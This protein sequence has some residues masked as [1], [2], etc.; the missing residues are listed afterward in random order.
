MANKK[1]KATTPQDVYEFILSKLEL[2]SEH[3][4]NLEQRGFSAEEIKALGYKSFTTKRKELV[5]ALEKQFGSDEL[6]NAA[7]PGLYKNETGAL[8]ISGKSGIA[9]PVRDQEGKI[10]AIKI[11]VDKPINAACKYLLLSSN[12]APDKKTGEIKYPFGTAAKTSIHFPLLSKPK[13]IKKLRITEGEIK[14]DVATSL[15]DFYTISLPGISMWRLAIDAI[16]ILRPEEI[17]IAFDSDKDQA[18]ST[19]DKPDAPA[20]DQFLVGKALSSLYLAIKNEAQSLGIKKVG[21]EHWPPDAG[22]GIDD[23]LIGGNSD[24]IL[25]L[26]NDDADAF[27]H[28]ML[29]EG[30]PEGWVYV[31]GI[32]RFYSVDGKIELDKE[33]YADRYLHMEKG[34]PATNALRNPALPKVDLP[35]YMPN[36]EVMYEANG[37]KYFNTWRPCLLQPKPG[38]INRFMEHCEYILPDETERNIFLDWLSYNIQNPGKKIL[39]ALLMQGRQG[40]GKSYFGWL[41]KTMLGERNVS[42]PTNEMLHEIYTAWAKSCQLVVIEEIMAHGRQELMNKFKPLIT[43]DNVMI[44][45]MRTTAY[46]QPNVFNLLMFTNHQD[47]ILIDSED[48]RYCV[49]FSPAQPIEHE[50]YSSLWDWSKEH[51]AEIYHYFLNRDIS[52]FRPLAHAPMTEGKQVVIRESLTPIQSWVEEC[53]ATQSW[54]FMGELVSV[55]HLLS[56]VP[57]NIKWVTP[58]SLYKALKSCGCQQLGQI[59]TLSG[60]SLRVWSVRRHEIWASAEKETLASEYA[61][62]S[63]SQEPGG[64]PLLE[65][66]PM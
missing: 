27:A 26:E 39:W 66:K 29:A 31:I 24:R 1:L 22:K 44:R 47:A 37:Y 8:S 33:Q 52:L 35:I 36:K 7:V 50:Y 48:R 10:N 32:K 2:A 53:I 17:L 51:K 54:P 28:G 55:N 42:F 23:V 30:M 62:W 34:N 4:R 45:D 41:M 12:P 16:K 65:A 11:R 56:C 18:N 38:K 43:Q 14:A 5:S 20:R 25:V 49:L 40:T 58:Q 19:Y 46:E 64:N 63:S 9:I 21:I 15:T 3:K 61:R 60:N 6:I 13:K 57:Q 59:K